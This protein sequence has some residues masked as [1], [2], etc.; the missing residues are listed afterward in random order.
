[1]AAVGG[2]LACVE[3]GAGEAS[4]MALSLRQ[5]VVHLA[6]GVAT[7]AAAA[8]GAARLS[9]IACAIAGAIHR[10]LCGRSLGR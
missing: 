7:V 10:L 1:M 6:V 2:E 3:E 4:W 5:V 9:V 8:L